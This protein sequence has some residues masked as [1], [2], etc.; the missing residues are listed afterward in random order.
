MEKNWFS[1]AGGNL[2]PQTGS[3][4][5]QLRLGVNLQKKREEGKGKKVRTL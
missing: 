3:V 2:R 4:E 5:V 1:Q